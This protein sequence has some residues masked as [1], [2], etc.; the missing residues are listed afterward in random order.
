MDFEGFFIQLIYNETTMDDALRLHTQKLRKYMSVPSSV[1][2]KLKKGT[3]S[4]QKALMNQ[5]IVTVYTF[6]YTVN[7]SEVAGFLVAPKG[8]I[9]DMPVIIYNRGGTGD[10]GLV[11][12][13][14]LFT[15]LADL[16]AKGYVVIGSQYPGNQ[17]SAGRD[18]RGGQSDLMSISGIHEIIKDLPQIDESRV[19]MYGFSRGGMMTY[20]CLKKFKWVKVAVILAGSADL[21]NE[22]L[23]RPEMAGVYKRAFGNESGERMKRSAIQWPS[24]IPGDT[25]LLLLHASRDKKVDPTDSISMAR[26]LASRLAHFSLLLIDSDSHSLGDSSKTRDNAIL[27]WFNTYL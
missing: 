1:L 27:D 9:S 22:L 8:T 19:G 15:H 20:I 13:G 21:D 23:L 10:Y 6:T 17:L 26:S 14:L 24:S 11:T 16:A 18:E 12:I 25:P 2:E 5:N 4:Y 3:L 7:G